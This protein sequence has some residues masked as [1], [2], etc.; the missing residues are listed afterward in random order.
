M[1]DGKAILF[2]SAT[3]MEAARLSSPLEGDKGKILWYP[4]QV[5]DVTLLLARSQ[6]ARLRTLGV[7]LVVRPEDGFSGYRNEI[8]LPAG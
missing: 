1:P 4:R 3:D 8:D 7:A 5:W 2:C 6:S